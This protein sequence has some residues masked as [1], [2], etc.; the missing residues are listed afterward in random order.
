MKRVYLFLASC[1]LAGIGGAGG[2]ILGNGLGGKGLWIGG[3]LGGLLGATSAAVVSRALGWIMPPQ[4]RAT[5]IGAAVGFLIAA[6]I[7]VNTLS[8]PIGPALSTTLVGI[9]ALIGASLSRSGRNSLENEQP[10]S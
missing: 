4:L 8:S 2:S 7:A 9:G 1:L 6:L 3:V 10:G 5:A